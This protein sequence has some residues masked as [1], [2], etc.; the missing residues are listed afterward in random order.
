MKPL[1]W[2][3]MP[4]CITLTAACSEVAPQ[5]AHAKSKH[6]SQTLE[7]QRLDAEAREYAAVVQ[8]D[9]A[10]MKAHGIGMRSEQKLAQTTLPVR[11]AVPPQA[12]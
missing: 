5:E 8:K 6:S 10:K 4:L 12:N 3:L 7:K 11:L 9:I 1:F 2:I